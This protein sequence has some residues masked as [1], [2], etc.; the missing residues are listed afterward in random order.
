MFREHLMEC[1]ISHHEEREPTFYSS[2]DYINNTVKM[3]MPQTVTCSLHNIQCRLVIQLK[4]MHCRTQELGLLLGS[5]PN[6]NSLGLTWSSL[7]IYFPQYVSQYKG[8]VSRHTFWSVLG[9][10]CTPA[11]PQ[12][13][14]GMP[15]PHSSLL[16]KLCL[17]SPDSS[18]H[19]S[20]SSLPSQ[21]WHC[22]QL[23]TRG[24]VL[25]FG[26]RKAAHSHFMYFSPKRETWLI[27]TTSL[28]KGHVHMRRRFLNAERCI[29][30]ASG[31]RR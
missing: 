25:P 20:L 26:C 22:S 27:K 29:T 7:I 15:S 13:H 9:L 4:M 8:D 23:G 19:N 24:A 5:C 12:G 1:F 14:P 30:L 16:P 21:P 11:Y 18:G 17:I 2:V 6:V 31:K 3:E 28:H 10:F